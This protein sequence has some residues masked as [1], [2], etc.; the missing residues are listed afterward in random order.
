MSISIGIDA[1]QF[2]AK[3]KAGEKAEDI[4]LDLTMTTLKG[5]SPTTDDLELQM[6]TDGQ[7]EEDA[8]AGQIEPVTCRNS[9]DS[10]GGADIEAE[11]QEKKS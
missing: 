4:R 3:L 8:R 5:P 11:K 6:F 2:S 9:F 7:E 1:M 10:M